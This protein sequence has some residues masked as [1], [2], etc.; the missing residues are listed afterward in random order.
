MTFYF[1]LLIKTN[2][3]H[4]QKKKKD[5]LSYTTAYTIR[6]SFRNYDMKIHLFPL[7]SLRIN[8]FGKSITTLVAIRHVAKSIATGKSQGTSFE[9]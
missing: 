1:V 8:V 4:L 7:N 5:K 9:I 3:P 6:Y 2:L